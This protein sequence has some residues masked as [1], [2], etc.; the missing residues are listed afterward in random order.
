LESFGR[1]VSE[2]FGK[3]DEKQNWAI[4]DFLKQ[5]SQILRTE[6]AKIRSTTTNG[7]GPV[8]IR[9]HVLNRFMLSFELILL[10]LSEDEGSADWSC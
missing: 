1:S 6:S 2:L 5:F 7:R 4:I 9:F 3:Y 10:L 8:Q